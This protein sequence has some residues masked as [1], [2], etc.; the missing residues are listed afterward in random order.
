ML[1]NNPIMFTMFILALV[2]LSSAW[3]NLA[4]N[5]LKSPDKVSAR[6]TLA[7]GASCFILA[8]VWPSGD[9]GQNP[10]IISLFLAAGVMHTYIGL[11]HYQRLRETP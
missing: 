10:W 2:I 4:Y 9:S 11:A 7:I 8:G 5:T 6:C 3:L 1:I